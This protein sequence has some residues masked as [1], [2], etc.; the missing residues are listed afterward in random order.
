MQNTGKRSSNVKFASC[1]I[2]ASGRNPNAEP[3]RNGMTNKLARLNKQFIGGL[4]RDGKSSKVLA[5]CN[6]YNAIK[7][8][9]FKLANL[10][11]L[12]EAYK[13]A[14]AAQKV[15][16]EVNAFEKRAILEKA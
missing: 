1:T 16:A 9:D 7:I 4:W 11:D 6:P 8:A 3:R 5:D 2:V 15:W 10:L 12:D 13:S 14:A